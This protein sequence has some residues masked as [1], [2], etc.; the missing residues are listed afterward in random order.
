MKKIDLRP[1]FR[2]DRGDI[3]DLLSH[4]AIDAVT[5]VTFRKGAVRGNHHHRETHQ[6]NYLVSGR[7]MVRSR[8]PGEEAE[9]AVMAPG[10]F[11]LASP[12]ESHA[13]RALEDSTL[14]VFTRGPRGGKEYETDTF[15]DGDPL[16]PPD[17]P[18]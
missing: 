15:R 17:P 7:L 5:L 2:D 16:I 8:R 12:G 13:L 6:W 9:E 3:V 1:A 4:E 18:G 14:M 11:C 10:D